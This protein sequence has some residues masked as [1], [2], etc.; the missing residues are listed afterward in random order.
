LS[1]CLCLTTFIEPLLRADGNAIRMTGKRFQ[2]ED[3]ADLFVL[4]RMAGQLYIDWTSVAPE[5]ASADDSLLQI[6]Q[7]AH[8]D[9]QQ[10]ALADYN[11][12]TVRALAFFGRFSQR[13]VDAVKTHMLQPELAVSQ[14]ITLLMLSMTLEVFHGDPLT[15]TA[16]LRH[17]YNRLL[18]IRMHELCQ[19]ERPISTERCEDIPLLGADWDPMLTALSTALY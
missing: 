12:Q 16:L 13:F 11:Y 10:K 2:P 15:M 19:A 7:E 18:C 1:Y 14:R 5:P 3:F 17:Y 9:L 4:Q 6:V 8:P